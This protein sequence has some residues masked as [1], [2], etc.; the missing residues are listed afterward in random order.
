MSEE[1]TP[2]W[3]VKPGKVI[4]SSSADEV[5][6]VRIGLENAANPFAVPGYPEE[7]PLGTVLAYQRRALSG[8]ILDYV[9]FRASDGKWYTTGK[10]GSNGVSWS[11]VW[12]WLVSEKTIAVKFATDWAELT[13]PEQRT[14]PPGVRRAVTRGDWLADEE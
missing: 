4:E 11:S 14:R 5:R 7:P 10:L 12:D 3:G 6:T 9:S 8:K 13:M 2:Y 1:S